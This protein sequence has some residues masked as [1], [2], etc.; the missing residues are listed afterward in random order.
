MTNPLAQDLGGVVRLFHETSGDTWAARGKRVVSDPEFPVLRGHV[1]DCVEDDD[2]AFIAACHEFFRTHS[3]EIAG[4]LRDA[5][6]YRWL[7]AQNAIT[8]TPD[9][10][11]ITRCDFTDEDDPIR[12]WVG[13]N[14]DTAIDAAMQQGGGGGDHG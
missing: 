10:W 6:R 8:E 13:D 5:E 9:S 3:A 4:A 1:A 14:L 12:Y 11:T 7:R 2:A